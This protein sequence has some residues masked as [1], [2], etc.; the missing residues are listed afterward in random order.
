MKKIKITF[1]IIFISAFFGALFGSIKKY[2]F[3]LTDDKRIYSQACV[4]YSG[5]DDILET[6]D[7]ILTGT[8]KNII[9]F[10]EYDEYNVNITNVKKGDVKGNIKIRNY[11]FNY[12]YS[13]NNTE[14]SGRTNTNY[15]EGETY[16]FVLQHIENVYE[17]K[18]IILS[19]V[20]IPI[21]DI[22]TSAVLSKKIDNIDNPVN[23]IKTYNFKNDGGKGESLSVEYIKN[24][25]LKTIVKESG[26]I[27][28]VSLNELYRSTDT[29]DVYLCDVD[30]CIKGNIN[31][32]EKN[33]IIIPF[34]KNTVKHKKKYIVQL[35]SDT[36]D[37]YIYFLSSKNSVQDID[38]KDKI[39]K[40]LHN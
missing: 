2:Q 23:Y 26:Y 38:E 7:I 24:D 35:N 30:E 29:V 15:K 19:D 11:L 40:L 8:I 27:V 14:Y 17:D 31:M 28:E 9:K 3:A 21:A 36:N 6:S 32:S 34:F 10:N 33:Q 1:L 37:S 16:V 22:Q 25:D 18:Y 5:F 39:I 13:Y 12:S 20:Y 4:A